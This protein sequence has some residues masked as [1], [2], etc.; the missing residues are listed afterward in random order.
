[1][2]GTLLAVGAAR[3][4]AVLARRGILTRVLAVLAG[5]NVVLAALAHGVLTI[6]HFILHPAI[7]IASQ[8]E[9]SGLPGPR[10]PGILHRRQ[11]VPDHPR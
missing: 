11:N 1:M 2:R 9:P 5:N 7:F 10:P 8:P 6:R 4:L 3:R